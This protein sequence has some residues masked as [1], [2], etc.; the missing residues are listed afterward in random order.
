M[1]KLLLLLTVA[2]ASYSADAQNAGQKNIGGYKESID[3]YKAR[4]TF[5]PTAKSTA[6]GS[7]WYDHAAAVDVF[8]GGVMEFRLLPI[9]FDST[10]LQNFNTGLGK[11]NYIS[12]AQIIDPIYFTLWSDPNIFTD[13]N[14][15][16]IMPYSTY[17]VDSISFSGAYVKNTNRSVNI[18]DTLILS[19]SASSTSTTNQYSYYYGASGMGTDYTWVDTYVPNAGD[20]IKGFTIHRNNTDVVNRASNVG[21][22]VMWKIPLDS[23]MRQ[24]DSAGFVD[25]V[26]F[27]VPVEVNGVPGV[28]DIPAGYGVAM[29]VTFKSGDVVV[30]NT[31]TFSEYHNFMLWSGEALGAGQIMPYYYYTMADRN[32]SNLMF[33]DNDSAYYPSIFIEGWNAATFSREFH[34][35]QAHVVCDDCPLLSVKNIN[36]NLLETVTLF[37]NPADNEVNV[38]FTMSNDATAKVYI[39]NAMGQLIASQNV[40]DVKAKKTSTVKFSTANMASGIYFYTVEANGQRKTDRF[41]VTH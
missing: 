18:V 22:R 11:I 26:T 25:I 4:N 9:W 39:T 21:G 27:T 14:T 35:M 8:N 38:N 29:T 15:I 32:S 1:K 13:P 7:R 10:V 16:Q 6:S 37:P 33:S 12:V 40:N 24:E 3:K 20:T 41:V 34:S 2:L 30:P 23:S 36:N 19:V 5:T 17:K 31:D 28:V